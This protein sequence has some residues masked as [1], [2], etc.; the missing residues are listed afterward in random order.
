VRAV[1]EEALE[2]ARK[3]EGPT[4][5]EAVT[6]RLSDHTT[7]DDA[8]RYRKKEEVEEAWKTEPLIRFQ[9]YLKE[10]GAWD[11]AKEQELKAWCA[12][13]VEGAVK[14]YEET[15]RQPVTA[16]FDYL[17]A[18]LPESLEEQRA[19]AIEFENSGGHH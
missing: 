6:Y 10:S 1:M 4:L 7:A 12:G 11:D 8:S 2:R 14:A 16:M 5:V 13:E 9:R 3:G 15:E 18:E 19:T 17:Y